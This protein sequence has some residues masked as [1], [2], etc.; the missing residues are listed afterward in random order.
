MKGYYWI[1]EYRLRR[2]DGLYIM[3]CPSN[4]DSSVFTKHP[5]KNKRAAR[6][7]EAC[8]HRFKSERDMVERYATLGERYLSMAVRYSPRPIAEFVFS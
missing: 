1:F 3:R 8:G 5:L 4:C 7:L 2:H 6:H